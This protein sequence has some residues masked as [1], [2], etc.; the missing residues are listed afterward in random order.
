MKVFHPVETEEQLVFYLR[1]HDKGGIW[2]LSQ[3]AVEEKPKH[4]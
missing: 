3:L 4:L 2:S 1:V